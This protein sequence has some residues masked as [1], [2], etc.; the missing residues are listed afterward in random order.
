M[1]T[2]CELLQDS[3]CRFAGNVAVHHRG[4]DWTYAELSAR[5][6]MVA[7]VLRESGVRPGD[8]V[9]MLLANSCHYVSSY[10]GILLAGGIVVAGNPE[11]TQRE[12]ERTL[13]HCRPTAVIVEARSEK[14]AEAMKQWQS[15]RAVLKTNEFPQ[16][17]CGLKPQWEAARGLH[18]LAQ[19]IY[20]SGTSGQPKGVGLTHKNL[21]ANCGSIVEY[22]R[23]TPAD[24]VFVILPFYY[25]YG[26][27][28]LL[29]HIAAGGRL[30]LANDFV[31]WNRA[32]DLMCEQ[33]VTGFSGVPSS[34]AMLLHK[35]DFHKRAFPDLRYL[36]CA[37]G[38]L[39]PAVANRLRAVV[40][41]AQLFLM[42][43]QTE[44]AA[45]L[46]TLLPEDLDRKPGSIGRGIPGVKLR[47]IY[48]D[49]RPAD[50]GEVGEI[51][52]RGDN[53]MAG[54]WENPEA[55]SEVLRD[56]WLHTGDLARVDEEGYIYIVGRKSSMIKSGAYR[57][58]PQ[59]I[60]E[61]ILEIDGVAEVAVAGIPD[62]ILG[63][64][65]AAF[66]VPSGSAN[67]ELDERIWE[68][69]RRC[70]PR[71]KMIHALKIVDSLP[72]TSS[73]KIKRAELHELWNQ[74]A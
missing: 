2:V 36:T 57:L 38:G 4:R 47:V 44:G 17:P 53:I 63:E 5:A 69:C 64:A 30:V 70:L 68:H 27:S 65:A 67:G 72:K 37:G 28:L 55:T 54:Y 7:S 32:L 60:E 16:A 18:D 21:S 10:F 40:P 51:V 74:H 61:T 26:N 11:T 50:P 71:H 12:L 46:S 3:A 31:F 59:E 35:S 34:F 56:G 15:V 13:A 23:L 42:Y 43:G 39:A 45:R 14:H 19:I 25:S 62:P 20:T 22:L 58:N 9:G 49:G 8:R 24:S 1:R 52:A 66:I 48:E 73:G 41:A 33:R 6:N 29:T